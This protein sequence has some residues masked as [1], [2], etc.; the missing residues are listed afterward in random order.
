MRLSLSLFVLCTAIDIGGSMIGTTEASGWST[1][2]AAELK[3]AKKKNSQPQQQTEEEAQLLFLQAGT[4]CV[5][6]QSASGVYLFRATVGTETIY[7]S[8]R[9]DRLA[10]TMAT[11]TFVNQFDDALF[12][13]SNP[14]VAITFTS[15]NASADNNTEETNLTAGQFDGS[16]DFF[17][18]STFVFGNTEPMTKR[19]PDKLA[20]YD[21]TEPTTAPSSNNNGPLIVELS[22]PLMVGSN[23][24]EYTM[25]QSVSQG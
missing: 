13:T 5:I 15:T 16:S 22:Q 21:N 4:D 19:I 14:N 23:I 11:Q 8:E 24:I 1:T 7:F 18:T 25:T 6:T 9:P 20:F 2:K 3:S 10:G 17:V 12:V